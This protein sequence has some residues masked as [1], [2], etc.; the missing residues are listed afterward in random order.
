VKRIEDEEMTIQCEMVG[1]K[2]QIIE[3]VNNDVVG[4]FSLPEGQEQ[5]CFDLLCKNATLLASL[6]PAQAQKKWEA[7]TK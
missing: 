7:L 2:A 5:E 6:H 3:Y 1:N 4:V